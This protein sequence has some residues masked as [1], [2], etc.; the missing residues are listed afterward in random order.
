MSSAGTP[1]YTVRIDDELM[2][3]VQAQLASLGLHS[4]RG[5]WDVS[6]FIRTAVAEKLAKMKRSREW[7]RKVK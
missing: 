5:D 3:W 1:R 6:E 4:P 2:M 7:R